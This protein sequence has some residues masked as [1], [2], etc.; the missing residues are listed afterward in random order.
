M[1]VSRKGKIDGHG[2]PVKKAISTR[3]RAVTVR[4]SFRAADGGWAL[5]PKPS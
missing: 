2:R 3:A 5:A 1:E 4:D